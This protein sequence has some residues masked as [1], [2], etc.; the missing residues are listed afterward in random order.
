MS[1][2]TWDGMGWHGTASLHTYAWGKLWKWRVCRRPYRRFKINS[3]SDLDLDGR[4][5]TR[6]VELIS[7]ERKSCDRACCWGVMGLGAV[8]KLHLTYP[9]CRTGREGVGVA[10]S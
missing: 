6:M 1:H 10:G 3:Y 2:G 4:T 8:V 7:F 9:V 5:R